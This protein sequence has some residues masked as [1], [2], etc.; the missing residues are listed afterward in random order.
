MYGE[1]VSKLAEFR[2][3]ILVNDIRRMCKLIL[4]KYTFDTDGADE[5]IRKAKEEMITVFKNRY[6]TNVV[7][8]FDLYQTARDKLVNEA[9]CDIT[10]FF[11]DIFETW[12]VRIIADRND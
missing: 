9:S 2:N 8:T 1:Q 12:N 6:P 4:V 7:I 3:G 10:I 11:P 5:A